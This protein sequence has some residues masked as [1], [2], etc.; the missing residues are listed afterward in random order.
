MIEPSVSRRESPSP[1][2]SADWA[3]REEWLAAGR[4]LVGARASSAWALVDWVSGRAAALGARTARQAAEDLRISAGKFSD[5]LTV[6][7]A[8]PKFRRWNS[9]QFSHHAEV[10]R[11]DEADLERILDTAEAEDWIVA[12]IRKA[13]RDA[14]CAAGLRSRITRLE[15]E[16]AKARGEKSRAEAALGRMERSVAGAIGEATRAWAAI[17]TAT[18][19]FFD[20]DDPD[21]GA[22]VHG[23]AEIKAA[24]RLLSKLA[25]CGRTV[26]A[27]AARIDARLTTHTVPR[28]QRH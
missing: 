23:N 19:A 22:S 15:R 25:A 8:Y 5:Y 4:D 2:A 10:A 1:A 13:A 11:L 6:S 24:K 17:D 20:G 16:L 9:L 7:K 21:G 12:R 3:T 18:A 26:N 27:I 28:T 14:S